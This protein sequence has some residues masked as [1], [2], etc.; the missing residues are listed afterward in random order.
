MG[1]VLGGR[2]ACGSGIGGG[3]GGAWKGQGRVRQYL[4]WWDWGMG[5]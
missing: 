1:W 3:G 4:G 2:G 5:R